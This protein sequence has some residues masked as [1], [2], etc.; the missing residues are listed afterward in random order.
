[1]LSE[2]TLSMAITFKSPG[3]AITPEI[4]MAVKK[5]K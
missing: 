2:L 1:M 4:N 5:W 3:A